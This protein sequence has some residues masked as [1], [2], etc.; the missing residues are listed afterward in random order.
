MDTQRVTDAQVMF[1]LWRR[2]CMA[3]EWDTF[4]SWLD[5]LRGVL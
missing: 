4:C 3:E 2:D 5:S 1:A